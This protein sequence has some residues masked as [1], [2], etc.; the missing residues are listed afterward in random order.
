MN[1]IPKR[2]L[3]N[4]INIRDALVFD[5]DKITIDAKEMAK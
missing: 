2:E 1:N 3:L 4:E 5:G